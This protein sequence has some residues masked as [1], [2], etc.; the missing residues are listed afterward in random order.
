MLNLPHTTLS[1]RR[2]LV[3]IIAFL[4]PYDLIRMAA[5]SDRGVGIRH[6]RDVLGLEHHLGLDVEASLNRALAAAPG[7]EIAAGFWYAGLHYLVTP[8]VLLVLYRTA[9]HRYQRMRL[10][11]M[12]ATA[13]ALAGYLLF[14]TAPP[15]FLPGYADTMVAT[16]DVGWWTTNASAGLNELAAMPSMHV[17]WALWCALVLSSLTRRLWLKV[18]AFA[19]PVTTTL[20]VVA[21]A[22]HWVLDAVAGAALVLGAWRA[23]VPAPHPERQPAYVAMSG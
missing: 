19:Y 14:P 18:L 4:V 15:R 10:A 8:L 6:A 11:L 17:G 2:E 13:V 20:V 7:P 21:T 9:P 5:G 12:I 16:A 3:L 1:W 22:N 23:V